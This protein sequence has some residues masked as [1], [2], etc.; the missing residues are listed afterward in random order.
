MRHSLG[1]VLSVKVK[2]CELKYKNRFCA[3]C[4]YW[5]GLCSVLRRRQHSIGRYMGDGF[6][7]SKDP[8][9]RVEDNPMAEGIINHFFDRLIT[10]SMAP[11]TFH[12]PNYT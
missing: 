8:T 6:Y 10:V 2:R 3:Y 1:T 4:N 9:N 11:P 12:N 7:R 5:I